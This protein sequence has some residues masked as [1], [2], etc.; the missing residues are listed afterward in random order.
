MRK[1]RSDAMKIATIR[2]HTTPR[3]VMLL[4]IGVLLAACGGTSPQAPAAQSTSA[5]A[6]QATSAPAEQPTAAQATSAPAEQPTAAAQATSA[7]AEQP[8]AAPATSE[9]IKVAILNKELTMDE[10]KAE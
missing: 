5:P 7:P 9:K 8:T 10:I 4:A 3:L 2:L 6:A 1:Q